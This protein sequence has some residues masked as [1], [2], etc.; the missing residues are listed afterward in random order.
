MIKYFSNVDNVSVATS[1][2]VMVQP[3]D[4]LP[5]NDIFFFCFHVL[6]VCLILNPNDLILKSDPDKIILYVDPGGND[7]SLASETFIFFF[8]VKCIF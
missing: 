5:G 2:V 3:R 4:H 6:L 8:W 7:S 1:Q